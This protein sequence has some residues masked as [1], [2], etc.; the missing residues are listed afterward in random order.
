MC[1][2]KC[3][4]SYQSTRFREIVRLIRKRQ[5]PNPSFHQTSVHLLLQ[6]PKLVTNPLWLAARLPLNYQSR[7]CPLLGPSPLVP[8]AWTTS[9]QIN[10]K[11]ESSLATTFFIPSASIPFYLAIHHCAPCASGACCPRVCVQSRSQ[12]SWSGGSGTSIASGRVVPVQ[13]TPNQAQLPL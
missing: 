7:P 8:S 1:H 2:N 13:G 6:M 9:S 10:L 5:T 11:C 4:T 3:S 12:T